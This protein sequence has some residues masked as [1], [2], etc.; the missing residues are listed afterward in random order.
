MVRNRT[1]GAHGRE[2][3]FLSVEFKSVTL[4][5][6]SLLWSSMSVL[7]DEGTS[8]TPVWYRFDAIFPPGDQGNGPANILKT[9][10][11]SRQRNF[12]E[13]S[14]FSLIAKVNRS[15]DSFRACNYIVIHKVEN[16]TRKIRATL[17]L[18]C[19]CRAFWLNIR[20]DFCGITPG[21]KD[22]YLLY[23]TFI[24]SVLSNCE[25]AGFRYHA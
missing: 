19:I 13:F 16:I 18:L 7:E 9:M 14:S 25:I 22:R 1:N 8:R 11:C 2:Y 21:E 15:R 23:C 6:P 20:L 10:T 24:N 3:R 12:P 4:F 17:L 5:Q